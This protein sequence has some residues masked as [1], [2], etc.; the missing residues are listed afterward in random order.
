M[1]KKVFVSALALSV[2]LS[3]LACDLPR[4]EVIKVG[5]SHDCDFF[6][7]F[8]LTMTAW[9]MGYSTK[10]VNLRSEPD[11][12]KAMSSVDGILVPGGADIDQNIILN[13]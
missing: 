9:G 8:R 1:I 10:I 4:G 13:L 7:R 2:S 11:M 3:G 5:C 6:Y 12:K